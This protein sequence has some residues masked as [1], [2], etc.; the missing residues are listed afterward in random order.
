MTLEQINEA[1][2]LPEKEQIEYIFEKMKSVF[3]VIF[4]CGNT[5]EAMIHYNT[6]LFGFAYYAVSCKLDIDISIDY[7]TCQI[8][9]RADCK[10]YPELIE[11]FNNFIIEK[12]EASLAKISVKKIAHENIQQEL[13]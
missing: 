5:N 3:D 11:K 12:V 13:F 2:Q 7:W 9:V 4:M 8:R 1:R 10:K 6:G